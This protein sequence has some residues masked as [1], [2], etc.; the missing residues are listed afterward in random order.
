MGYIVAVEGIDGAGKN[1]LSRALEKTLD[2]AGCAVAKLG[3]PAYGKTPFA[4]FADEALHGRLGDVADSAWAMALLFALD[5][6]DMRDSI[7]A[8]AESTDVLIL[9]RYVASNAAYS[10]GRTG[11]RAIVDWVREQEFG[12]HG[13]PV[14]DLQVHLGTTVD[15][16]ARRARHRESVDES[17]T[18]D[19]YERDGGLQGRVARAYAGLAAEEW[20]S[21]WHVA[22]DAAGGL[23][24]RILEDLGRKSRPAG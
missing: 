13:L 19:A 12:R 7:I 3:F 16:A 15:E 24:D 11:D 21:P 17:R 4:D 2:D 14:P 10:W 23:A 6:R 9:D 22:G 20:A 5:R 8:A 1:T 18:R